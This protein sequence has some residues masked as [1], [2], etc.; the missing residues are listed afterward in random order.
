MAYDK[1]TLRKI[2]DRRKTVVKLGTAT[3][4]CL[5]TVNENGCCP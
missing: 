5:G 3:Y 1:I 2:Y 4:K